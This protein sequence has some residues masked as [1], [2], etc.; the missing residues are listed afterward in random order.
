MENLIHCQSV[1]KR[2]I[3]IGI[4]GEYIGAIWTHVKNR[5]LVIEEERLNFDR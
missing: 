4:V 1:N 2:Q 3:F 5:P